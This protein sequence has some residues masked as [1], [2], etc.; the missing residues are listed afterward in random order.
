MTYTTIQGDTWDVIALK[1]LGS[2]MHS[3]AIMKSNVQYADIVTFSAG[4]QLN[5]PLVAPVQEQTLP[6]WKRGDTS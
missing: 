2:E 1:T 4:V 5:I 3:T 6:P